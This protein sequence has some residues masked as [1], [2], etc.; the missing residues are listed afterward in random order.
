[1]SLCSCLYLIKLITLI[2]YRQ[3]HLHKAFLKWYS[4]VFSSLQ[5]DLLSKTLLNMGL[6]PYNN[7]VSCSTWLVVEII[8][9]TSCVYHNSAVFIMPVVFVSHLFINTCSGFF[10][11]CEIINKYL[12][13][14]VLVSTHNTYIATHDQIWNVSKN[15]I[16]VHFNYRFI[17]NN[18]MVPSHETLC[19]TLKNVE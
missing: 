18:I 16:C 15:K 4:F 10:N 1:M 6:I 12:D 13:S 5:E 17:N 14:A 11:M 19:F 3:L 9:F 7:K 8:Y 2:V